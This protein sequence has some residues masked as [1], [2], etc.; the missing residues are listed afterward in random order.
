MEIRPATLEDIPAI[1]DLFDEA[2]KESPTY[3]EF[4]PDYKRQYVT[5]TYRCTHP[6]SCFFVSDDLKAALIGHLEHVPWGIEIRAVSDFFYISKPQRGS[7]RAVRLVD[8]YEAWAQEKN[9]RKAYIGISTGIDVEGT[10]GFLEKL[11]Y[12][13]MGVT[14]SKEV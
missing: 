7:S 12:E 2:H 8:A 6:D 14:L 4:T 13:V 10:I 11:D 1:L 9:V 5:L 3:G